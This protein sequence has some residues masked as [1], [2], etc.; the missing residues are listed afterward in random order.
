MCGKRKEKVGFML[1]LSTPVTPFINE[2]QAMFQ[3]LRGYTKPY[4]AAAY[5][6]AESLSTYSVI[7]MSIKNEADV[8]RQISAVHKLCDTRNERYRMR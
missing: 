2:T 1:T 3:L 6:A 8:K 4:M 5:G 7:L